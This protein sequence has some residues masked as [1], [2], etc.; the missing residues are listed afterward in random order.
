MQVTR[1]AFLVTG[2]AA[3]VALSLRRLRPGLP[4]TTAC[5][6]ETGDQSVFYRGWEDLYRQKWSWDRVVKGTHLR[7]NCAS[8]CSW[9]LYVKDGIVWREEQAA[10]LPPT[11]SLLP[12]FNP[13]GCQKGACY[14][15]LMYS[16][17]RL[18][19][20]LKRVGPRGSGRWQKITWEEALTEIADQVIDVCLTEGAD[21]IVYDHGTSNIDFGPSTAAEMS[22]FHRLGVTFLE[23]LAGVG[24]LPMGAIQ[25]WGL[26]SVDGTA[27]DWCHADYIL[28]WSMNPVYTR[29]P[30]AHFLCE[31]RYRG[32]T[33]VVVAP[34]YNA[35]AIHADLW[36]NPKA[37]TDAALALGMAH[38]IIAEK[39]YQQPYVREQTDLPFLVRTDTRQFL[40][41]RDLK[42]GGRDDIFYVWDEN[43]NAVAEAPGG[44]GLLH[45][46]LALK[47]ISP[48]LEGR[49]R[50]W[51]R[52]NRSAV[53]RPVFELLR[54]RLAPYAP[55][56][57]AE[58]T[59]V[60]ATVIRKVA[61]DFARAKAALI[62]ASYGSCKHYHSDLLQRAMILLAALTGNQ[63][64]RGGGVRFNTWW[65]LTGFEA[66]A[67]GYE[68]GLLQKTALSVFKPQVRDIER[69]M[70]KMIRKEQAFTP[71]L[72]WLWVHGGLAKEGDRGG[73]ADREIGRSIEEAGE[74]GWMPII[75][76]PDKEPRVFF[77]TC[78]N[79]LRRW[80]TPQLIEKH[81]WPKLK[82]VV[83]VDFRMSTT[84]LKS[85]IVLPVAGY[86]EKRGI[87]YTQS[88]LPYIVFGDQ[89]VP[90]LG[91]SKGEWQIYGLLAKRI[92]ERAR[93]RG[94]GRYRDAMGIERDLSRLYEE[95]SF[96]GRFSWDDD[97]PALDYILENSD[98]TRGL[99]WK[100]AASRGVAPIRGIGRFAPG[101]AT[102][103]DF[104]PMETVYPSQWFVEKKEP[105]PTLT[106]RQQF[107]IDH[108]W[109][110][111][112]GEELP[113][114]KDRPD[115]AS[116]YRLRLTG[117]HT[118][119]SIHAIWRDQ[120]R[121]LQL[122]RGEPVLYISSRDAAERGVQDHD[123]VTVYNEAGSFRIHAKLSPAVQPGE[124]IVYH[125]WEPYQFSDWRGSQ[126]PVVSSWKPLHLVGDY[127]QLHFR[128]A[129]ASPNY[130]PRGT[131]VEVIRV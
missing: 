40:R 24:D 79:P 83:D 42:E 114:H 8:A 74:K 88:Y 3:A 124:V 64:K 38:V 39:L 20:P 19:Y 9:N 69:F 26:V 18:K 100:E 107:Y 111:E 1:R 121:M 112:A 2:G 55:E 92:Q 110:L 13:R 16:P 57:V 48:A 97:E 51:L 31:A 102:C 109:Y 106:G 98:I 101:N 128:V 23:S 116:R 61:R 84:G 60:A 70:T 30:E 87:K 46:S 27:D 63:G 15:A 78:G 58:I 49:Y 115:G 99:T 108:R 73:I 95:W 52:E 130:S 77:C 54:E 53:V 50:V 126:E 22:F 72:P 17:S 29:I 91:E 118:R 33:L 90:P 94:V 43:K 93:E 67:S 80:P 6:A 122:Q 125:A 34:D 117:G 62:L 96:R 47:E 127:G 32:T 89:A 86:Y 35:T 75:P 45:R 129:Y 25:T 11:N 44:R 56:R 65:T 123:L 14:S 82:L 76:A 7:A 103:S 68:L 10:G 41:E 104:E 113:T 131:P 12:D 21:R 66:L 59:G 120:A 37:A 119:W 81:L 71:T 36:L 85:D 4:V 105:W 28:V 5:A